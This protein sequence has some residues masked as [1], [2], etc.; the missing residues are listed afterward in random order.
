M[1][2]LIQMKDEGQVQQ[3]INVSFFLKDNVY[4]DDIVK[5]LILLKVIE[6]P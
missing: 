1:G 4:L 5:F 3:A 2:A 6:W